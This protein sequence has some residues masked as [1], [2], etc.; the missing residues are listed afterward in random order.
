MLPRDPGRIFQIE[1]QRPIGR[2]RDPDSWAHADLALTGPLAL[3]DPQPATLQRD[4]IQ[5]AGHAECLAQ[6][7]GT[8]AQRLLAAAPAHRVESRERLERP[9]QHGG[10]E[11]LR[12]RH[13]VETPVHAV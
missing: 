7:R 5:R 2:L 8:R 6:P 9:D 11:V 10:W 12:L 1:P 3:D 13:R 4:A